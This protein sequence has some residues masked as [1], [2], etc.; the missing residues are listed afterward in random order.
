ME[1]GN[2]AQGLSYLQKYDSFYFLKTSRELELKQNLVGE[3]FARPPPEGS[4]HVSFL[5]YIVIRNQNK[6]Y[7]RTNQSRKI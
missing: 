5:N 3:G 7:W 1:F 2:T 6:C 4:N